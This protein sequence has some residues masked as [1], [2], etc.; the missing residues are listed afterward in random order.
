MVKF[1]PVQDMPRSSLQ[2]NFAP[3]LGDFYVFER[4]KMPRAAPGAAMVSCPGL[5]LFCTKIC[6][7][8]GYF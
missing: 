5:E 8:P 2:L 3:V 4:W 7:S 6:P 1:A